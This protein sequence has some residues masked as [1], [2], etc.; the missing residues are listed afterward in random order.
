LGAADP[1]TVLQMGHLYI[2]SPYIFCKSSITKVPVG[3]STSPSIGILP[4][5]NLN[6]INIY[7]GKKKY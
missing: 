6:L 2:L 3:T 1:V 4:L 7:Y 5:L